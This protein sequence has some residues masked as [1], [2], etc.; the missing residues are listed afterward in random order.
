MTD[1]QVDVLVVG[2]G[3]AGSTAAWDLARRG[4][5]VL[6]LDRDGRVKPCGGAV[7]PQLM[8]EFEVPASLLVNRV[9]CARMVSPVGKPARIRTLWSSMTTRRSA[10]ALT[11]AGSRRCSSARMRARSASTSSSSCTSTADCAMIGPVSTPESTKWIVQPAMRTPASNA[12]FCA[13][14]PANAGSSAG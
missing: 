13:R 2:G 10:M 8:T 14:T 4:R 1:E 5:S 9:D 3:P 6:L 12:C 11:T 7:P